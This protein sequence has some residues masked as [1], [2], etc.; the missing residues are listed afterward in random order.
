MFKK[1]IVWYKVF[2]SV[3]EAEKVISLNKAVAVEADKKMICLARTSKG[4]FA[5]DDACPHQGAPLSRGECIE[6]GAI[7]C[8]WHKY[9]FDL[10]TGR[11]LG[12]PGD[13]TQTYPV[14][15][16]ED[17]VYIGIT[18]RSWKLF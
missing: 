3:A 1:K 15:L 6:G 5:L 14:E 18:T 8:P 4:F 10:K 16:R 2:D 17:G 9:H 11:Y 12:G 7:V 13:Y